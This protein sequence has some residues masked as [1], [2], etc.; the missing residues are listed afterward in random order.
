MT[1]DDFRAG[2]V[3]DLIDE[4]IKFGSWRA[5]EDHWAARGL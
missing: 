5:L 2:I 3:A 1:I 4:L